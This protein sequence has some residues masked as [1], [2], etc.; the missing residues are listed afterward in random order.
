MLQNQSILPKL[1]KKMCILLAFQMLVYLFSDRNYEREGFHAKY[2]IQDCPLNCSDQGYCVDHSCRCYS[3]RAGEWCEREQC[4][5]NCGHG[6]CVLNPDDNVTSSCICDDG[7]TGYMCNISL[8]DAEGRE[9]WYT[10][11]PEGMGFEARSAHA[12][13]FLPLTDCLYI[14]GGFTLNKILG[15]LKKFCLYGNTWETVAVSEPWPSGRY[16]HAIV[17]FDNGFYMFGGITDGDVYSRELW[18]FNVTSEQWSLE[19]VNSSIQPRPVSGHSLTKVED[20]LYLFGGKTADGRFWETMYKIDGN[21]PN[22]WQEVKPRGGK[23]S[24]RRL[25]GHSTVYHKESKS[26][27]VYGGYSYSPDQPRYGSHTDD[28]QVFHVEDLIWTGINFDGDI[29]K[30]PTQRSFHSAV[31]MGNYMVVY[32]GNTH[33]HHDLE[34]CYDYKVYLYHLGCHTWVD[35]TVAMASK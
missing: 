21:I 31:I 3:G 28:L 26:L 32:G 11:V 14:F 34:Q 6:K 25:V 2:E 16:E 4:P 7:Y 5:E 15:D 10:V 29:I 22:Q 30:A 35:A 19:A 20:F 8:N 18:F 17:A 23:P 33:I 27:L 12:G 24:L 1:Q 13:A 9:Y